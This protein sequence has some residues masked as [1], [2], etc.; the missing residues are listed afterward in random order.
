MPTI[1]DV[2]A[3]AGVSIKTVSRVMNAQANVSAETREQVMAAVV[4]LNY[5]PS[6]SARSLAGARSFLLS[7]VT[8]E[9][10]TLDHWHTG[11]GADYL[12]RIQLGATITCRDAGY[13]LMIAP[14]DQSGAS[15]AQHLAAMLATLKPDGVILTPPSADSDVVLGVLR[16]TGTPYVRLAPERRDGGGLRLSLDDQRAAR[17]MAEYLLSLG[18]TLI[19]FIGG[20]ERYASSIS[21]KAGFVEAMAARGLK[22][23][24]MLAGDYTFES[25]L[26]AGQ[27]MLSR[28]RR[29]T[30]IFASNDEMALGCMAAAAECG[31]RVPQDISIAGFDDSGGS[32]MSFPPLTTLRQPIDAMA[33]LA[34]SALID[35][36]VKA[37]CDREGGEALPGFE[38][39]PR[40]S[41][42]M[43]EG[44][45]ARRR[46]RLSSVRRD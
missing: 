23:R 8:D 24:W 16:A 10:L 3:K 13:H 4:E 22:T 27:A 17:C 7:V 35:G 38:L 26:E 20:D 31:L 29:P 39:K 43:L 33:A 36:S 32:R 44:K 9:K 37:D 21:R 1:Y 40:Q 45:I 42:I 34:A 15:G 6:R 18:H 25:G 28:G 19:G 12:A 30:A 11:R 5:H 46:E 2:A 14:V 41:T